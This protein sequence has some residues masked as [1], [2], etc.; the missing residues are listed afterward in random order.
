MIMPPSACFN[1]RARAGRDHG[2]VA[3]RNVIGVSIH[4]P[5]RGATVGERFLVAGVGVSIHAPA[6]GATGKRAP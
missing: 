2:D 1:P 5:A 6:R 4:A 3:L